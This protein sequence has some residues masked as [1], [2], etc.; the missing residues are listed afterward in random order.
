MTYQ[1]TC[2]YLFNAT[3]MFERQGASGYKEGLDN[4]LALDEHFDHPH[5]KFQT[6]HVAGTNG[7]GSCSHTLSAILQ[8]CGYKVGLYTSPHLVDFC[9]R[10]RV[11][12]QTISEDY[13]VNF[14]EQE[15]SFIESLQ[16]SFFEVTTAM[17]FK[18][19][20]D[21]DVDIAVIEVGLGGRLDCTNI[22]TPILSVITN[23]GM[24]HTQ[25][26]GS[27]LEQIAFGKAGIIKPN[28]PVVIGESTP[29][30]RT[31]FD[32]I[33]TEAHA[34]ITYADDKLEVLESKTMP[35][36]NGFTYYTEHYGILEGELA[37]YYQAKNANTVLHAVRQL[38][39]LGFMHPVNCDPEKE[40]QNKEVREGFKKVCELTGL[41]GRWQTVKE[42]PRTVCDTG[43]NL[44]GWQYLSEQLNAVKCHNMH[45]L[46]G[47]VDDKDVEGV[48]ALLP[49]NAHYYFA[50]ASTPRA[51][52]ENILKL[53]AQQLGLKGESYPNVVS[54][55]EDIKIS[56]KE[57]DFV[58]IGGSSYVVADFLKN[59]I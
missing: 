37:G 1:E 42:R 45:I 57:D 47:M 52:S 2:E 22:I 21:K 4:S 16:P 49:K 43:H 30:T 17:A 34:P 26:L 46:F 14:V 48:M 51:V 12:G 31:V 58:F 28:V 38:E 56:A 55:Y 24:D 20:A 9:E 8:R 5:Q 40:C 59:C 35:L 6:I 25:F 29:E 32:A 27:S 33:A 13:V 10:I 11:N 44:P 18:Y 3:P 54:A 36:D 23:I 41:K 53:Y 15:K 19:F 7:K 50:K 39:K